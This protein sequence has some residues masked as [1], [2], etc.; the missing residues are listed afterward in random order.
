MADLK[1]NPEYVA[2]VKEVLKS[3]PYFDLLTMTLEELEPGR[4]LFKIPA[5]TKHTNPFSRVHG[6]VF[7]SVIDAA[8]FWAIY[9][10]VDEGKNMTTAELKINY[11]GPAWADKTLLAEG[12][13]VK[14]GKTLGVGEARLIEAETG[15]LVGFGTA[16]CM[17]LE[18]PLP[19]RLAALTPKFI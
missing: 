16:T 1:L 13:A 18:P 15:R 5:S 11:L 8:T 14:V 19:D 17:I 4:S 7:A 10:K 3:A 6:G 2:G 12:S 9:S